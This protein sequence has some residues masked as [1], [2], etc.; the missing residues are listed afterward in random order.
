MASNPFNILSIRTGFQ[1]Y[2]KIMYHFEL[3]EIFDEYGYKNHKFNTSFVRPGTSALKIRNN[4]Y[5]DHIHTNL[6]TLSI[7]Q[8]I[9]MSSFHQEMFL[10]FYRTKVFL[11]LSILLCHIRI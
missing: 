2:R 4:L 1:P 7:L 5:L 9:L 8:N 10:A 11:F 3:Q 6:K